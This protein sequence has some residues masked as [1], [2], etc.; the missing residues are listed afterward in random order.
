METAVATI[1]TPRWEVG[2]LAELKEAERDYASHAK[3]ENT[4]RAYRSD[5]SQ[6]VRWCEAKRLLALPAT[7]ETVGLYVSA[8]ARDFCTSTITRHLSAVSQAHQIA[9]FESPT[10]A[11]RVRAVMAGIRRANGTAPH[12]KSPVI[13]D[14]LRA[15]LATI[16]SGTLGIRDRALLLVGFAGAFRRSELV[17]LNREDMEFTSDGL[18]V[19]LRRSKTDQEGQGRKV[20][21]PI[22]A[23]PETCP[24]RALEKWLAVSGIAGGALFH[25]VDRYGHVQ[26]GRLCDRAVA[27]IV[28]RYAAA[29]GKDAREF[30]GHS[31]RAGL[32]TSAAIAGASERAIMNQTGHRST[33]M[34]RRYIR[35]GS[36]FRDNAAARVGL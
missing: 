26:P 7:P 33:A 17:G 31:L 28:K 5:W 6:F 13:I 16:P 4:K 14:D 32:A 36:L 22:G 24:V 21:I 3:A 18:V 27:L 10:K 15:M 9:G 30:A 25:S 20:G 8:L 35:D 2:P 12:S 34:V 1:Q 23:H 19:T 29:C 11:A